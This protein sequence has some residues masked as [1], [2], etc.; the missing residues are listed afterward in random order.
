MKTATNQRYLLPRLNVSAANHLSFDGP[1]NFNEISH[2]ESSD[3]YLLINHIEIREKTYRDWLS[4]KNSTVDMMNL[5]PKKNGKRY[6]H[7][8]QNSGSPEKTTRTK[9][10]YSHHG[11][12]GWLYW[13]KKRW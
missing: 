13:P 9:R 12:V 2:I 10:G 7:I 11:K 1:F 5:I 8:T 4:L 6:M 3:S